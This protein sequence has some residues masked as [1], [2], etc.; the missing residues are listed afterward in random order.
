MP[1]TP[2]ERNVCDHLD[3]EVTHHPGD[4]TMS[5]PAIEWRNNLA[6]SSRD[7]ENILT[8]RRRERKDVMALP[9]KPEVSFIP[10]W[11][12]REEAKARNAELASEVAAL[13]K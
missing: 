3:Y 2:E 4:P 13:P 11:A 5:I 10:V 12:T 9:E 6:L 1:L 7:I 8:L